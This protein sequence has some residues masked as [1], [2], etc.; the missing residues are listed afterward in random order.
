MRATISSFTSTV[1][2]DDALVGIDEV[3]LTNNELYNLFTEEEINRYRIVNES[4]SWERSVDFWNEHTDSWDCDYSSHTEY[5]SPMFLIN[6]FKSKYPDQETRN[7]MDVN[8]LTYKCEAGA[9]YERI[10]ESRYP[11]A[12]EQ[13]RLA[14]CEFNYQKLVAAEQRSHLHSEEVKNQSKYRDDIKI[15]IQQVQEQAGKIQNIRSSDRYITMMGRYNEVLGQLNNQLRHFDSQWSEVFN[16]QTAVYNVFDG[17]SSDRRYLER[18]RVA[19]RTRPIL[20][21]IDNKRMSLKESIH[22]VSSDMTSGFTSRMKKVLSAC[23]DLVKNFENVLGSQHISHVEY[24]RIMDANIPTDDEIFSIRV[25]LSKKS[26]ELKDYSDV[27]K[28]VLNDANSKAYRIS[29]LGRFNRLFLRE[30]ECVV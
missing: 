15:K 7:K 14:L 24:T 18:T 11:V 4:E 9:Y 1:I 29:M 2:R 23:N 12:L 20:A 5:Y 22:V 8:K 19:E 25:S 28:S 10:F 17:F 6:Y 13:K 3:R 21:E 26:F 27:V 16:L 30:P